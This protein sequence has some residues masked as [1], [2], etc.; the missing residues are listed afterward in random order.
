MSLRRRSVYLLLRATA[1]HNANA[2]CCK[3][4]AARLGSS[5]HNGERRPPPLT[6]PPPRADRHPAPAK[7]RG[8]APPSVRCYFSRSSSTCGDMQINRSDQKRSGWVPKRAGDQRRTDKGRNGPA[9]QDFGLTLFFPA[10][11]GNF[12]K[13]QVCVR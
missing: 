9:T 4:T 7:L 1:R 11:A 8:A 10:Q 2:L 3:L 5:K 13:V 12:M 6:G